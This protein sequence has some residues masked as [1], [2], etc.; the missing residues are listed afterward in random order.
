V[1]NKTVV[2]LTTLWSATAASSVTERTS[3]HLFIHTGLMHG[4]GELTTTD[5]NQ[6]LIRYSGLFCNGTKTGQGAPC[7]LPIHVH[8][9]RLYY[10]HW[11]TYIGT[12]HT[13]VHIH[14]YTTYIG[15]HT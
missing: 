15:T 1:G 13:L 12:Q 9:A 10:I 4:K 3:F 11:Y 7:T 8:D 5:A 6:G 2:T 14:W